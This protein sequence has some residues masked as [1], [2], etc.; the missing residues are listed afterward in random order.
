MTELGI[1]GILLT[2]GILTAPLLFLLRAGRLP[3]GAVSILVG[4]N[5]IAMGFLFDRGAY[6]LT[7]VVATV[8]SAIALDVLRAALQPSPSRPR[9]F[10]VFAAALATGP[11]A[12]YFAALAATSGIVWSTHLWL[13]V[14]V[15]VAALGWLLSYLVLPPHVAPG[16]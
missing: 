7:I 1:T 15:F 2:A 16:S 11:V 14:I 4:L 12:A 8:T 13:G 10:R 3:E 5:A 6:P 9:A